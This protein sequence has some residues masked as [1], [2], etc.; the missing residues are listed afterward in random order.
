MGDGLRVAEKPG[1]CVDA[2]GTLLAM[3][4]RND[5]ST[6]EELLPKVHRGTWVDTIERVRAAHISGRSSDKEKAVQFGLGFLT[7]ISE[8]TPLSAADKADLKEVLLFQ[9]T[10]I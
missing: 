9:G 4:G 10:A 8:V 2:F 1:C 7:A 6:F 5:P 3:P